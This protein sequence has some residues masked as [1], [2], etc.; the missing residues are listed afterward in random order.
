MD[1]SRHQPAIYQIEMVGGK[2][3]PGLIVN[4][5]FGAGLGLGVLS[6]TVQ[7]IHLE[8]YVVG[9]ILWDRVG[10]DVESDDLLAKVSLESCHGFSCR[11]RSCRLS[12]LTSSRPRPRMDRLHLTQNMPYAPRIRDTALPLLSPMPRI[13]I[14]TP[15]F[16]EAAER[17]EILIGFRTPC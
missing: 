6:R 17:E 14:H 9:G 15:R 5:E 4:F 1:A 2:G 12:P 7:V 11:C 8:V 3:R 10:V 13:R 16:S